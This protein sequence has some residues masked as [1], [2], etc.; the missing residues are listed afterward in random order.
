MAVTLTAAALAEAVAV[1]AAQAARLLPVASALVERY[2][3]TAPV[4]VQNEGTIRVCG[5][6]SQQPESAQR[7]DR[8]GDV[9]TQWASGNLAC[10]IR[11]STMRRSRSISSNSV[12]RTRYRTWSAP[13]VAHYEEAPVRDLSISV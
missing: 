13:S 10:L 8:I 9:E 5:Y 11:R 7:S 12:R 1:T 6:L 2:A 3:P 4:A